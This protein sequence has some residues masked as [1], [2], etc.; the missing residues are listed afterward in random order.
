MSFEN[1]LLNLCQLNQMSDKL[2]KEGSILPEKEV[3]DF[4]KA[5]DWK[6]RHL[7][8]KLINESKELSNGNENEKIN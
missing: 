3:E 6:S 1:D 2:E 8:N 7:A 4:K 5:I